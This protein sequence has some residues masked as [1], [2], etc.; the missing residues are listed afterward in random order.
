M[1]YRLFTF[2]TLLIVLL[3]AMTV[4]EAKGPPEGKVKSSEHQMK[5]DAEEVAQE[6]AE[7]AKE[8]KEL[9]EKK[10][11][12]EKEKLKGAEKQQSQK[13]EQVRKELGK[14]SEKG[15]AARKEHSKKWWKFG[16]GEKKKAPTPAAE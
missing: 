3:G 9:K 15:Q 16:F 6:K 14:G 7:K 13:A 8:A 2:V 11:K 5:N 10:L 12:K 4:V 1:T